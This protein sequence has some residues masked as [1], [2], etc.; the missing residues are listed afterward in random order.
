[1][2]GTARKP[3]AARS[4]SLAGEEQSQQQY[5]KIAATPQ[6]NSMIKLLKINAAYFIF[7]TFYL[8]NLHTPLSAR[9]SPRSSVFEQ[10][11]LGALAHFMLRKMTLQ[12]PPF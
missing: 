4:G 8:L 12:K 6:Q 5:P 9:F 11:Y 10:I 1:M 2:V 7:S 3:A